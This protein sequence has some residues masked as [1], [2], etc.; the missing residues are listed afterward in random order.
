MHVDT[1]ATVSLVSKAFY[2]ERFSHVPL[3]NTDIELKAYAAHNLPVCGQINVSVSYQAQTGVLPL[4]LVDGDGPPLLGRNWINKI[5]L[6]WHEIFAVIESE[7][8]PGVSIV[9][10]VSSVSNVSSVSSVLSRHP[11]V[12]KLGLGTIKG[13]RAAIRIK[14]GVSPVFCKARPVP[15]AVK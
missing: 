14:D 2:K 7:S 4:V 11:A 5:K 9:S 6:D 12:F 8:V 1:G 15:Y 3:A 13:H 10:S